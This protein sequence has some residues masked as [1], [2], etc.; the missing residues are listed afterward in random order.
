MSLSSH[1]CLS[2]IRR[3]RN[4]AYKMYLKYC[5]PVYKIMKKKLEYIKAHDFRAAP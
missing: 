3:D 1:Y 2:R 5:Q 4:S